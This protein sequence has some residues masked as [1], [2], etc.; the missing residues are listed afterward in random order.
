MDNVRVGI[1]GIAII[2]L[3]IVLLAGN[4]NFGHQFQQ[5]FNQSWPLLI[6][7]FGLSYLLEEEK[8]ATGLII[9]VLGLGLFGD[10]LGLFS[11]SLRM[12][13]NLLW[14]FALI[15][16]GWLM[17]NKETA[18]KSN[19]VVMGGYERKGTPWELESASYQVI[20]GGVELDLRDAVI[21][22]GETRLDFTVIMG[23]VEIRLPEGI[24]LSCNGTA[25]L[26]GLEF[27]GQSA[28]GIYGG[29]IVEQT[30]EDAAQKIIINCRVLLG[31]VDVK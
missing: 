26:G 16:F 30:P 28:G 25:V 19:W 15:Y 1:I 2:W 14:S 22:E 12:F 29:R 23:G 13:W 11:F 7:T 4:F 5:V 9:T 6:A 10:K 17:I 20:M 8:K 21:P 27:L 24:A 31:G 3:G 18:E